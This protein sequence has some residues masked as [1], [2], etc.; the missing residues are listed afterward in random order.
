MAAS[1][2]SVDASREWTHIKI[3]HARSAS[4]EEEKA[5]RCV[6]EKELIVCQE[7][8]MMRNQLNRHLKNRMR[9]N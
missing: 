7:K 6:T 1:N 2:V 5:D 9:Q 8:K 3:D 4:F